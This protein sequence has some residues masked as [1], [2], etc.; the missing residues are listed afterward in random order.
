VAQGV[1]HLLCKCKALNANPS[2][3]PSP[4]KKQ[5][6][7]KRKEESGKMDEAP[8]VCYVGKAR[9]KRKYIV[10]FICDIQER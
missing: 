5:W 7:G 1:Q 3:V 6:K 2:P 8:K 10:V 9:H 4:C